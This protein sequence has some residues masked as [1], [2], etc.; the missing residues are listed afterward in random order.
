MIILLQLISSACTCRCSLALAVIH[1]MLKFISMKYSKLFQL[2]SGAMCT[3]QTVCLCLTSEPFPVQELGAHA[4]QLS[5]L[6]T[7]PLSSLIPLG[8]GRCNKLYFAVRS[9]LRVLLRVFPVQDEVLAKFCCSFFSV[10]FSAS[11]S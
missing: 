7:T 1:K 3:S 5:V 9:Y 10:C 11:T 2:S 6:L 8:G 4:R